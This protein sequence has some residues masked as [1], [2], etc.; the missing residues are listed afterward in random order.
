MSKQ[1]NHVNLKLCMET[2][3]LL[4][5][6]RKYSSLFNPSTSCKTDIIILTIHYNACHTYIYIITM[7]GLVKEVTLKNHNK[8]VDLQFCM[9]I[10]FLPRRYVY[11]EL[12]LPVSVLMHIGPTIH[13]N[14]GHNYMHT[15]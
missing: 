1:V 5:S 6:V 11:T 4:E 3:V 7:Q 15:L 10:S 13:Y 9:E 14:A 8:K 2:G 12:S